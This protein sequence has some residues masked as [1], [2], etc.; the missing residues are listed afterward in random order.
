MDSM[1]SPNVNV[2]SEIPGWNYFYCKRDAAHLIKFG[3]IGYGYWGPNLARNIGL[4]DE[5]V[6]SHVADLDTRRL[7]SAGHIYPGAQL[8][9][10][11]YEVI[12]DPKV[13]AVVITTPVDTHFEL[14]HA[15][16]LQHKHVLISKPMTRSS[17]E[18]KRLVD[19]AEST[20][21]ILM[22]DHTFL[23]SGAVRKIQQML[24]AKRIGDVHYFHSNRI[25]LGLFRPDVSVLWDLAPHDISILLFLMRKMPVKVSAIGAQPVTHIRYSFESL[26]YINFIFDNGL[27]AHIHVSWLS[28]VKVRQTIIGG[29]E[30][31]I[32]YNDLEPD[33]PVKLFDKGIKPRTAEEAYDLLVQYRSGDMHAP[34]V[35]QKEPLGEMIQEFVS[36]IQGQQTPVSDGRLGLQ[37]VSL[38]EAAEA[39]IM[40]QGTCISLESC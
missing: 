14:A 30:Q 10:S 34:K 9:Q 16:L 12:L 6:L 38:L 15:A 7:R 18:A 26:A 5:A 2:R 35:D 13:D 20:G 31:M 1:E 25:N 21:K 24:D 37:V 32:V 11:P 8:C 36:A 17:E 29:S 19:L 3:L 23:Y 4:N 27:A 22:V 40:Q 33:S 39:S 28:P